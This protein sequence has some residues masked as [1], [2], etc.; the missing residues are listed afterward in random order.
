MLP[1][2]I[3]KKTPVNHD[4]TQFSSYEWEEGTFTFKWNGQSLWRSAHGRSKENI[5]KWDNWNS[6]KWL[7]SLCSCKTI[8]NYFK[9]AVTSLDFS[10]LT[11]EFKS[12][13]FDCPWWT[14]GEYFTLCFT[15]YCMCF[16]TFID[17]GMGEG[18]KTFF[19]TFNLCIFA[20]PYW[21][22]LLLETLGTNCTKEPSF[23]SIL[24]GT[25]FL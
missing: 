25:S 8:Q 19:F 24:W 23:K 15:K 16:S 13:T 18:K 20:K 7:Q 5:S 4:R 2:W 10:A 11:V 1:F 14:Y 22:I 12:L 9:K 6:F 3:S 17:W 21:V